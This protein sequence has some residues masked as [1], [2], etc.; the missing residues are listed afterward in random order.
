MGVNRLNPVQNA[1]YLKKNQ[2]CEKMKN[3]QY[4]LKQLQTSDDRFRGVS[5]IISAASPQKW[6]RMLS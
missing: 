6:I 4:L 5:A 1:T 3:V 2:N